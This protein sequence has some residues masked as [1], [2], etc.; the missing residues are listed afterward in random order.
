MFILVVN[1]LFCNF[2]FLFFY[3]C[4]VYSALTVSANR[5]SSLLPQVVSFDEQYFS[6]VCVL[7]VANLENW[8]PI[9]LACCSKSFFSRIFRLN[10]SLPKFFRLASSSILFICW[11]TARNFISL[12]V[13]LVKMNIIWGNRTKILIDLQKMLFVICSEHVFV[14]IF[15]TCLPCCVV[16]NCKC[17]T[18]RLVFV[19]VTTA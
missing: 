16:M 3:S 18:L 6:I 4:L 11:F 5:I 17:A 2:L 7:W 10:R 8:T 19:R 12:H 15:L 14:Y 13:F 9:E 1:E